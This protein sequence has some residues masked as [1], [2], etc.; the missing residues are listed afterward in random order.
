LQTSQAIA[1]AQAGGVNGA[2]ANKTS[3]AIG[4]KAIAKPLREMGGFYAMSLDI[5]AQFFRPPFAWR[6]F[7]DQTWFVA[8][9]STLPAMALAI[10]FIT[11]VQYL[12]TL[13]LASIGARDLCGVAAGIVVINTV[14]PLC[15]ASV[16]C[17]AAASAMCADLGARTI[18]EEIDAMR[19]MG[20]NPIQ[21]LAVPRVAAL[22]LVA[23]LL[24]GLVCIAGLT[25]AYFFAVYVQNV[26]PGAFAASL[27]LL[28]GLP[29]VIWCIAK[30]AVFGFLGALV[31]CYKGFHPAPGP[32]GVGAAVNETVVFSFLAVFAAFAIIAAIEAVAVTAG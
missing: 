23:A 1:P 20:I 9:V 4:D 10:S 19:T 32:A 21:R 27:T 12:F 26:V 24:M 2:S 22:T 31:A 3:L 29:G 11:V 6:E 16:I 7:I 17:G 5:I 14:G 18:R 15:T 28:T 13:L 25:S 30:C 8:R